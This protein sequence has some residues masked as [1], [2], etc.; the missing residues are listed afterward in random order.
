MSCSFHNVPGR[1]RIKIAEIK[2]Q[3]LRA[4]QLQ[5]LFESVAGVDRMAANPATG[6]IKIYYDPAAV[7]AD[8]LVGVLSGAG[9]EID[10][11]NPPPESHEFATRATQ[12]IGKAMVNWALSKSLESS[13]LGLLA[14]F[15]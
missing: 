4:Q 8:Q 7:T 12:A 5:S 6:S 1:L 3:P 2:H 13:G 15:I 10:N 11:G 14:A 9:I